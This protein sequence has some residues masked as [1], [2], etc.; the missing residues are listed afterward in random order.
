[1]NATSLST[2]YLFTVTYGLGLGLSTGSGTPIRGRF[3]GRKA[4]STIQGTGAMINLPVNIVAPIY[5]GWVYDVTGSYST[6]F[7]QALVLLV[8]SVFV[9]YF[10]DPPKQKPDVTTDVKR[11][12]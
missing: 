6:V 10:Y 4:F 9:L 1:M 5:I 8:V 7:T 3:F 11:F 2:V 12:L